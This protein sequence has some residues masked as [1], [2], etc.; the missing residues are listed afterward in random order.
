M[1]ASKLNLVVATAALQGI[2][3]NSDRLRQLFESSLVQAKGPKE[4]EQDHGFL[5][6]K[7]HRTKFQCHVP[8]AS[9]GS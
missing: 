4:L 6:G 2:G 9:T 7:C 1:D 3:Y 8:C 5:E